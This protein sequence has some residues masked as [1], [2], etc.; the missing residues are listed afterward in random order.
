MALKLK[1]DKTT[2]NEINVVR[3]YL[4][5][6]YYS[7][8]NLYEAAIV[9]EFLSTRYPGGVG[10]KQGSKIAM[11]CYLNMYNEATKSLRKLK[12][13]LSQIEDVAGEAKEDKEA[14][15]N[16]EGK[17]EAKEDE[18]T[19]NE[20]ARIS[21]ELAIAEADREFAGRR[22]EYIAKY[23]AHRWVGQPEADEAWMMLV[24]NAVLEGDLRKALIDLALFGVVQ[25]LIL[26]AVEFVLGLIEGLDKG[27]RRIILVF[28]GTRSAE[29]Q[30]G[31]LGVVLVVSRHS[32]N[33]LQEFLRLADQFCLASSGE[34]DPRSARCRRQEERRPPGEAVLRRHL[35][36]VQAGRGLCQGPV[37]AA[38][39]RQTPHRLES[40]SR[41]LETRERPCS[42]GNEHAVRKRFSD[43]AALQ[44]PR[45]Y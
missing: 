10:A 5:Y 20:I 36:P 44:L 41:Q 33:V 34:I 8:G 28:I 14:G 22:L 21:K 15:E 45:A 37:G 16:K 12:E 23:I 17:E 2:V 32:G 39:V 7:T 42:S 13:E 43:A 29:F 11:A 26:E 27:G 25:F 38:L 30:Q 35:P 6:L 4:S 31:F 1:T 18:E 24:R 19:K 3:Y 40:A 9:G